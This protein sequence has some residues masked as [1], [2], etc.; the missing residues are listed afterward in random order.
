MLGSHFIYSSNIWILCLTFFDV[1]GGTISI[2]AYVN[3]YASDVSN[4]L[5]RT[6]RLVIING[7]FRIGIAAGSYIG[8]AVLHELGFF[9]HYIFQGS[10]AILAFFYSLALEEA[11]PK[12]TEITG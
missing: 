4:K 7:T 1:F 6:I 10:F 11:S 2:I 9:Y 8:G 12:K 3:A 5:N